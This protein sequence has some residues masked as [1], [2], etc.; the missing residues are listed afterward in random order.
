MLLIKA[1]KLNGTRGACLYSCVFLKQY[2]DKFTDVTDA[3]IKGGSGHCGVL[4]DGEWR[5]HYWC[6]GDVNGEPWVFDITIDQ[7]VSSPFICEPKD[8]LL[9]QY[10]SGPQDVID[11]RVLEMGF[12]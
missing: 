10:A 1:S 6:E 3:T 5:G 2:L 9:L 8:T 11:Q 12:R 7:F 4:V